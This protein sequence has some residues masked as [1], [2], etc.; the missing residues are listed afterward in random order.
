MWAATGRKV[1]I[2]KM[3]KTIVINGTALN[4]KDSDK[5]DE[6]VDPTKPEKDDQQSGGGSGYAPVVDSSTTLK[7]GVYKPD[8]F[9]WSG[10][11]GRLAYIKCTK[12]TVRG[13]KAYATIV[14][15]SSQ[16]D[17][18]KASGR[19]YRKSGGGLSTFV[20]PVNLNA[21]NKIIGRTT[22]M[23]QPH[24][25]DYIIYIG[26]AETPADA[27]KAQD[28]K[29]EA[30]EAKMEMSDEAPTILGLEA[31]EGE[32][33]ETYSKYFKIFNYEHGV[34]LL[35]IDISQDTE[36]REEYTENAK[37]A[38]EVSESEDGLEYDDEGNVIA[39]SKNEYIEDLYKNNI[40]NYLLVPEDYEVPA[41]LDK[42][43]IIV[44]IPSEKTFAAS[45]EVIA[46]MEKL[47]CL[48]SISL[49]GIDEGDLN[50]EDIK[51]ALEEETILSA[52][53]LEKPDYGKVIKDKT[54]LAVL[55][56]DLLPEAIAEDAENAEELKAE[57]EAKKAELEKLES[58]FTALEVPVI[59]DRS[60]QEE[61]DLAKAEWIKVYG[62]L[63]GC[64]EEADK[65]FEEIV[66]E[67][68]KQ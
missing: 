61:D 30:A 28:A 64:E 58:R 9:S 25:I 67:A 59:V 41:G 33:T 43:Y 21:N 49:L 31:E 37:K 57:A 50:S 12:I 47:G 16:Y 66:K 13:G 17:Q 42:E 15:A 40:V 6:T 19:T 24:W 46:F 60:A 22:A 54:E 11:S 48:D 23:S 36:L 52:G 26:L 34:K 5:E 55:P 1:T 2:N 62:A 53:N 38:M 68:D 51:K 7:D 32:E 63:F 27:E 39:K 18:L 14:F 4:P 56:G 20:I 10:G 65:I 3:N 8:S 35:S 44:N 45:N 29:K